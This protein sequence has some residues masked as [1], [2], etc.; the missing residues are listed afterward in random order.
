[1]N[2]DGLLMWHNSI[3]FMLLAGA[4]VLSALTLFDST[5]L[6]VRFGIKRSRSVIRGLRDAD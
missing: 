6:P 1:M 4:V 2:A 5:L 3:A